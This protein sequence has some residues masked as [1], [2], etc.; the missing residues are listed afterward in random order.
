MIVQHRSDFPGR[1]IYRRS[2]FPLAILLI[3]LSSIHLS[4]QGGLT[5][6]PPEIYPGD[7][8][9]TLR[10]MSGIREIRCQVIS[11]TPLVKVTGAGGIEGCRVEHDLHIFVGDPGATVQLTITVI[12]CN[13]H[14]HVD[15]T[16][17]LNTKWNV[18]R[19]RYGTVEQG[20]E[21]CRE[22]WVSSEERDTWLD[23][24]TVGDPN[25]SVV[26]P[27]TLPVRIRKG[28]TYRYQVCFTGTDKG[29]FNFPVTTW[30]RR[31]HPWGGYTNYAVADTGSINIVPKPLFTTETS[32]TPPPRHRDTLG[33]LP[34]P[35]ES[36][37]FTDP[38][39]FR[40][41]ATP[42][43]V[44]PPRGT[45]YVGSY[46]I[47]GLTAGYSVTDNF[48]VIAGG[49]PPLPDDWSGTRGEAFG[50]WSVGVKGGTPLGSQWKVAGGLQ[51]AQ[52]RYDREETEGPESNITMGLPYAAASYGDDNSRLSLTA[53]YAVKH[54]VTLD[55]GEF[56]RNAL[57]VSLGADR[58]VGDRWK[59]AAEIAGM[60]SLGIVPIVATVR[61][62]GQTW[63]ID[64]GLAILGIETLDGAAPS[65]PVAPVISIVA[66]F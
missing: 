54:H 36:P 18:T 16:I 12:D 50:A 38:T 10:V 11:T 1:Q 25:V 35:P 58:R 43:G 28:G 2:G 63:A 42:N 51:Y 9:I 37:E 56:D 34:P 59:I 61:Y 15:T 64:G 47:L 6:Q 4:A 53:G 17:A 40:T 32:P 62:F 3:L 60:E 66:L 29:E 49:A 13:S 8:T 44:I 19:I 65:T 41:I 46:D 33:S 57:F 5:V 26:L 7:N 22:F 23:S 21:I 27:T 39:T 55:Q 31:D 30:M 20:V 52:S 14:R 24:I 48:M 45:V